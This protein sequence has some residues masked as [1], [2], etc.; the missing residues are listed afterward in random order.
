MV[1]LGRPPCRSIVAFLTG[2]PQVLM[3]GIPRNIVT[4]GT[5]LAL[6][7]IMTEVGRAPLPGVMTLLTGCVHHVLLQVIV[8][9]NGMANRAI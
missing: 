2:S 5:G 6:Q 7:P 9:L 8:L 1:K 4:G 3:V